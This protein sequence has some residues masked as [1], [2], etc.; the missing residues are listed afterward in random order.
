MTPLQHL[1]PATVHFPIA[2]LLVGSALALYVLWRPPAASLRFATWLLLGVGWL[3]SV[4]AV[5]SGLFA[6]A[7][8]PPDAPYWG[9]LNWH[10][11]S[12]VALTVLYGG[13]LYWGWTY[14][15]PRRQKR[16]AAQGGTATDLLADPRARPWLTGLLVLGIVLIVLSGWNGGVLVYEFGVNVQS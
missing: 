8:L 16:R 4:A 10:I 14:R 3:G 2:L 11:A 1:H 12:G 7:G 13:V 9:V 5:L 6:Q 15:S